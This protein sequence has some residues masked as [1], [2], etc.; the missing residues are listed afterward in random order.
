MRTY[1]QPD[2]VR[3][4]YLIYYEAYEKKKKKMHPIIF[5]ISFEISE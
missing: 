5:D 2:A 3:L 4:S 1:I